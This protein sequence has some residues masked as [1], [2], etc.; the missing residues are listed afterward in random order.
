MPW[1]AVAAADSRCWAALRRWALGVAAAG[2]R[3]GAAVLETT[4]E[5]RE[6]AGATEGAREGARDCAVEG[7]R[8]RERERSLG[9]LA[10]SER[11]AA[12]ASEMN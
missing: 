6:R 5:A 1:P 12:A 7:A 3:V 9:V 4:D 8:E 10:R 11:R 2:A